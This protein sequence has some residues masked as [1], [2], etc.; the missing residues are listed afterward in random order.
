MQVDYDYIRK[1]SKGQC[2]PVTLVRR[3]SDGLEVVLKEFDSETDY[4][5]FKEMATNEYNI[6]SSIFHP[7]I[8]E[9]YGRIQYGKVF[10][11]SL[12]YASSG[13]LSEII[14]NQT[15]D[16]ER[17]I[18]FMIHILL[19]LQYLHELNIIHSDLTPGNV[20][21]SKDDD[22]KLGDFGISKFLKKKESYTT[23]EFS[24]VKYSSPERLSGKKYNSKEDV[25]GLGC[26]VYEM[27]SKVPPFC[28][29]DQEQIRAQIQNEQPKPIPSGFSKELKLIVDLML[30][31]NPDKRYSVKQLLELNFIK[32][33]LP[34]YLAK[35]NAYGYRNLHGDRTK[36]NDSNAFILFRLSASWGDIEG[37]Y[38][39]GNCFFKGKGIAQDY[40]QAIQLFEIAKNYENSK[41][42]N[43][44]GY[45]YENGIN[46]DKS[47]EKAINFY[48]K[49]F[50]NGCIKANKNYQRITGKSLIQE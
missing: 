10:Y 41:A 21:V 12:E 42:M 13:N 36:K 3:K 22:A 26:I 33:R 16:E 47:L 40:N 25:W 32:T 5:V 17:I 35:I 37:I 18:K 27:C 39:L 6:H 50:E 7:F 38:H 23:N 14:Q 43:K 28:H 46:L 30:E 9:F 2:G 19:G 8:I 34:P 44:I 45:C 48:K 1:I 15:Y 31:K 11:Y 20:F 24:T 29:Y 49:A 4:D